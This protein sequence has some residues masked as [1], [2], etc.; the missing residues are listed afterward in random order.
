MLKRLLIIVLAASFILGG[1]ALAT[2]GSKGNF[3]KGKYLFRKSCRSCHIDGGSAKV[4]EPATFT[5]DEWQQAFTAEKAGAYTCKPEWDKL[6]SKEIN[7]IFSYMH[8]Y[9][10]DSPTPAKCK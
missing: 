3:R 9:A 4:L 1:L 8:K 2:A 6:S 5:M 10:K 7:D